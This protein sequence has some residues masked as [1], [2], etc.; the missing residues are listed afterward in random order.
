M[1]VTK[2]VVRNSQ[3]VYF[4]K[5][6]KMPSEFLALFEKTNLDNE[7]L[8]TIFPAYKNLA[9][10]KWKLDIENNEG[11]VKMD[12]VFSKVKTKPLSLELLFSFYYAITEKPEKVQDYYALFRKY[13]TSPNF[14]R[15]A[16]N[17]L[18]SVKATAKGKK[19][20]SFN[21]K[22]TEGKQ[23]ALANFIGK[24]VF[25]DVW[26]TWCMPCLQQIPYIEDLENK[27]KVVFFTLLF[28]LLGS[29]FLKQDLITATL[30]SSIAILFLMSGPEKEEN[31][32]WLTIF[33]ILAVSL[34]GSIV[35]A[36]QHS[37]E[38]YWYLPYVLSSLLLV[39]WQ[40]HYPY[41]KVL[42]E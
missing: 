35:F 32:L 18:N 30:F 7:K 36:I 26:A 5:E 16:K 3:K 34:I 10:L 38:H 33:S 39:Y 2:S 22:N 42:I 13:V 8:Y 21:Y 37:L 14:I 12:Q 11:F 1:T 17:Q 41:K 20:P 40:V 19:S 4:G 9:S 27:F 28:A 23:V 29:A 6:I 31:T 15:R 24:Y 25:I